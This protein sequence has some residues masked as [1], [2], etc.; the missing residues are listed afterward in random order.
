MI[1][2]ARPRDN[3]RQALHG[4]WISEIELVQAEFPDFTIWREMHGGKHGDW[5]ARAEGDESPVIRA[6]TPK[7]LRALLTAGE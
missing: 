5:C 7:A 1:M 3:E 4:P 6:A 2:A